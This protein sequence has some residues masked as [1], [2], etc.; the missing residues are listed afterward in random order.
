[1]ERE[2]S[3]ATDLYPLEWQAPDPTDVP[4]VEPHEAYSQLC[5]NLKG[6]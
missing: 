4:L 3:E 6:I 1:M 2:E 5:V